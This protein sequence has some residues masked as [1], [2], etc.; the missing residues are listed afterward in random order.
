MSKFEIFKSTIPV[1]F[2][3]LALG[4]ACGVYGAK[5]GIEPIWTILAS[6][7]VYAGS[8]Q[9]LLAAMI[10]AKAS[11]LEV[12]IASFL[13]NFRHFFYTLSHRT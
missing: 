4:F 6:L 2:G 5:C 9:F 13:L 7:L 8:G 11:L 1:M 12:F 3:Y 10:L